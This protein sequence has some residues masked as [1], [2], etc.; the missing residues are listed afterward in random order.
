VLNGPRGV[1]PRVRLIG[2]IAGWGNPPPGEDRRTTPVGRVL[3]ERPLRSGRHGK[4]LTY[5]G[6]VEARSDIDLRNVTGALSR[7]LGDPNMGEGRMVVE[8]WD[9]RPAVEFTARVT[10]IELPE[11]YPSIAAL[12]RRSRG[13]ERSFTLQ[14]HLSR[15]RMFS[16]VVRQVDAVAGQTNLV[17]DAGGN[18]PTEPTIFLRNDVA[19]TDALEHRGLD[20][21]LGFMLLPDANGLGIYFESR[22][23]RN[24][25]ATAQR[26]SYLDPTDRTW[27]SH[28]GLIPGTQT[29]S[30]KTGRGTWTIQW[31][32]AWW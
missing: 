30:R 22:K 7:A 8:P 19:A 31:R 10:G 14:F 20:L 32:D 21:R 17:V 9:G 18:A 11:A 29:I 26:R 4:T 2:E 25:F 12:G 27:W 6:A 28:V 13:F 24:R 3:A 23:I 5:Q 1:L 15:G 16:T